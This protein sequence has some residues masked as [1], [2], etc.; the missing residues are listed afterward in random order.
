MVDDFAREV[1]AFFE[2]LPAVMATAGPG[3][4]DRVR[5]LRGAMAKARLVGFG[6]PEEYG[7]RTD[8]ENG[9]RRFQALS[10]GRMPREADTL[11]IGLNMALP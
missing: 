5:A 8:I 9:D 2:T 11:G 3:A 10:D 6:I 4:M 1:E 7:G